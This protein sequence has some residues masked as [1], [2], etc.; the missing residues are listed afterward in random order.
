MRDSAARLKAAAR[1]RAHR[2]ILQ[3]PTPSA[4][5]TRIYRQRCRRAGTFRWRTA[6]W[7]EGAGCNQGATSAGIDSDWGSDLQTP[8]LGKN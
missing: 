1:Q 6:S 4:Q 5:R 7:Q 3:V 8:M 2:A